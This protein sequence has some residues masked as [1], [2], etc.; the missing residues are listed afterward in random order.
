M[1]TKV[2]ERVMALLSVGGS[3]AKVLG[4]GVYS[5]N[6]VPPAEV[7]KLM[8]EFNLK[9]PKITLDNGDVV[10]GCECWWGPEDAVKKRIEGLEVEEVSI[11]DYRG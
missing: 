5:G 1:A 11:K 10:W 7:S 8:H 6:E 4:V 9:N 3:K 2:G